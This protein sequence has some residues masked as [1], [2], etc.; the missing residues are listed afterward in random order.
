MVCLLELM[1][2]ASLF[3]VPYRPRILDHSMTAVD[4]PELMTVIGC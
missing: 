4:M 1:P 3:G 2:L